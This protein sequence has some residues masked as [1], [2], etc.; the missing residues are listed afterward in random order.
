MS[1]KADFKVQKVGHMLIA[2]VGRCLT[3]SHVMDP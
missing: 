2:V 3:F 1:M